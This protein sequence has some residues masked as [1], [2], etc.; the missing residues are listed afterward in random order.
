MKQEM[1]RRLDDLK[2]M[3]ALNFEGKISMTISRI[4]EWYHHW[5]GKV[6]VSISGKDSTV[7]LHIARSVFPDIKAVFCDTGLEY[8]EVREL[9]MSHENVDIIRPTKPFW[10]VIIDE[11]YPL[12]SKETSECINNARKHLCGGGYD[13]HYRKICGLGEYAPK[14]KEDTG[15]ID[16][17]EFP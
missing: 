7:L 6:C 14:S 16:K 4:S 1:Q 2:Q 12:I 11:G 17:E 9:A 5:K 15:N 10:K 8:P 13:Q 3:Q